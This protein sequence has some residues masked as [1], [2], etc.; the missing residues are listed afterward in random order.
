MGEEIQLTNDPVSYSFPTVDG[1]KDSPKKMFLF[2]HNR[3]SFDCCPSTYSD[4]RGCVCTT[5]A[6][7]NFITTRGGNK[8]TGI[9]HD[10]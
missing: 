6:Q 3:S 9:Y 10:F 5:N 8:T 4:D 7:R 1:K 2:A